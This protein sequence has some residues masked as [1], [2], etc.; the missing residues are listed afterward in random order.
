MRALPLLALLISAAPAFA[1]GLSPMKNEGLTDGDAKGFW[2]TVSNPERQSRTILVTAFSMTEETGVSR[3]VIIPEH[4]LVGPERTQR[5]LVI[6]RSLQP[7][8]RFA[9]RVCAETPPHP[10]ET[11]HAR[12]CSK[13]TAHRVRLAL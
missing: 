5:V 13:L 9:F 1:V 10:E 2:L 8:E 4:L 7:D 11:L 12:V 6:A 3:V